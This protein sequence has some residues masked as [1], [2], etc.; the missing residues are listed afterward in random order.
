MRRGEYT[1]QQGKIVALPVYS[2]FLRVY[3]KNNTQ[4]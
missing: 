3:M 1:N 2:P 4:K